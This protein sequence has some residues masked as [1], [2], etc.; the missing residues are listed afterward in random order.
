MFFAATVG[1][2]LGGPIAILLISTIAPSVL[3]IGNGQ[4]VWR[5]MSTVAG[6]WIGGGANQA[7]MKEIFESV[8]VGSDNAL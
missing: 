5:G 6:S 3:D 7:S 4:E 2:V 8:L 1:I